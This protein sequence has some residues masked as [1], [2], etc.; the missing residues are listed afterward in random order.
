M[1]TLL[2]GRAGVKLGSRLPS[3]FKTIRE[4]DPLL[5]LS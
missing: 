1:L 4:S 5:E 2:D 3:A